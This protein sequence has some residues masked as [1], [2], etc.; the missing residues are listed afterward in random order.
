MVASL[1]FPSCSCTSFPS[2]V[3]QK[4]RPTDHI[5][6]FASECSNELIAQAHMQDE[7]RPQ[8]ETFSAHN[9]AQFEQFLERWKLPSSLMIYWQQLLRWS[10]DESLNSPQPCWDMRQVRRLRRQLQRQIISPAD[11]FP[12]TLTVHCPVQWYYL[13][14]IMQNISR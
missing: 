1:S 2:S 11:H 7:V 3:R 12:H 10:W 13:L 8:W 9:A 5:T 6:A 4:S 14:L